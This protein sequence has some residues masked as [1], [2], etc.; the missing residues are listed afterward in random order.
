[1]S[2]LLDALK[3]AELAK[4]QQAAG[5]ESRGEETTL[6]VG[7]RMDDAFRDAP[8]LAPLMTRDRLPD[9]NA[10]LEMTADQLPSG[11]PIRNATL[12][13]ALSDTIRPGQIPDTGA[14]S[15][16]GAELRESGADQ[17]D[18]SG[19]RVNVGKPASAARLWET[20]PS[21]D[22]ETARRIVD[23]TAADRNPRLP[24]YIALGVLATVAVGAVG[25][26]WW[27]LQP[28]SNFASVSSG[29]P[30]PSPTKPITPTPAPV[31]QAT[32]Q[33]AMASRPI[34]DVVPSAATQS[35]TNV[36]LPRPPLVDSVPARRES[37]NIAGSEADRTIASIPAPLGAQRPAAPSAVVPT[38]PGAI[39][40]P[41]R[42][43]AEQAIAPA[44]RRAADSPV[45]G[46]PGPESITKPA[47]PVSPP[48][49]DAAP[50]A[51]T[52]AAP[53][54]DPFLE[55]AYATFQRGDVEAARH[56]YL[57]VARA[58]P[59]NRDAQLGLAAVDLRNNDISSAEGRYTRLL[60]LD[61]RDP[62]ALAGIAAIRGAGDPVQSESRIKSLLTQQPDAAMLHFALGNQYASQSRWAEAQQSYFRAFSGE[63]D[64][65]D[66][67]FN[68]AVSLDQ[69]R[70]E[71][72][73]VDYYERALRLS[74]GKQVAFN[75]DR[76][77]ARIKELR[78]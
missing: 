5:D 23:S 68:L 63:P 74:S 25:F 28:K 21:D 3:K 62:H 56:L 44:Q 61:P 19:G 35:V 53:R 51:I 69:I 77:A 30:R 54:L 39:P 76:L 14:F 8:T 6:P 17:S 57:R 36:P 12:D 46:T 32:T 45:N 59:T 10:P 11:D 38:P 70:Q 2:L 37:A 18:R 50:I 41:P 43:N 60:D 13:F 22:R 15:R 24:F 47:A 58:D 42:P 9:I 7:T 49:A 40:Q 16:T 64:N 73:A 29:A 72:V 67:A 52:R 78:R 20:D 33:D 31:A 27:E 71:R 34:D 1:V 4:Q 65:P 66:F 75:R 55:E 26:F 48:A